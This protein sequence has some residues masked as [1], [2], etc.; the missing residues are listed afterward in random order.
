MKTKLNYIYTL[1]IVMGLLGC[2]LEED[3]VLE[4]PDERLLASL[5]ELQGKL[6]N[7]A[8]GWIGNIYPAG[9]KG[10][11]F[12]FEFGANGRVNML[13]DFNDATATDAYESS[14]RLK[15]LQRPTIIFD[16]YGYIHLIAD[17]DESISGGV[18]GSGLKSDFEFAAISISDDMLELEGIKNGSKLTLFAATQAQAEAWKG[19]EISEMFRITRSF[20]DEVG[21]PYIDFGDGIRQAVDISSSSKMFQLSYVDDNEQSI[22]ISSNFAFTLEGLSLGEEM[23]YNGKVIGNIYWDQEASNFYILYDGNPLYF[24]N[25]PTPIIPLRTLFGFGKQYNMLTYNPLVVSALPSKFLDVYEAGR[26]GLFGLSSRRLNRVEF[27]ISGANE[28]ILNFAYNN[29]AGSN[30]NA[31]TTYRIRTDDEGNLTFEF[32]AR[33]N[34]TNVVGSGLASII[35]YFESNKFRIDWVAGDGNLYGALV[36]VDDD[37]SY[38]YGAF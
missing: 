2:S 17:P 10:F 32:I 30:F 12:Y 5:E 23:T 7:A 21:F 18:R 11:S 37:E 24:S 1:F 36:V 14:Y 22:S 33:D 6:Q 31:R 20:L 29:T 27:T 26:A 34:N 28:A 4:N 16:T 3:L 38:F 15:A 35:N 25:S 9:G 8:H 13:S 19:G